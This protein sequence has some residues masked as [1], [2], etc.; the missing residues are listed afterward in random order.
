[1]LV[2][3]V[4]V[5]RDLHDTLGSNAPEPSLVLADSATAQDDATPV[6]A[7]LS[8]QAS[9]L[10]D[11]GPLRCRHVP[12]ASQMA[13]T[14][15]AATDHQAADFTTFRLMLPWP[16]FGSILRLTWPRGEGDAA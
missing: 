10:L 16:L 2:A 11:D 7:D 13:L 4:L 8:V 12:A 6:P 14:M 1:M 9:Q 3:D 5:H 15:L